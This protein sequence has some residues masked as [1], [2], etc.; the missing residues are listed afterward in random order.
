MGL[1][2]TSG[3]EAKLHFPVKIWLAY[4]EACMALTAQTAQAVVEFID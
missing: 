3:L 4:T 2:E 1:E